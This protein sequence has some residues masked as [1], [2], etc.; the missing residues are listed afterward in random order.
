MNLTLLT[1]KVS[2]VLT[3]NLN[4]DGLFKVEITPGTAGTL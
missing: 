4:N 1:D 2:P 3:R